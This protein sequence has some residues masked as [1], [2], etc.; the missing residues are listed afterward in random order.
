MTFFYDEIQRGLNELEDGEF[1]SKSI[2][3]KSDKKRRWSVINFDLV[4]EKSIFS[5]ERFVP[6]QVGS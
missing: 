4:D 2:C 1:S 3:K 5:R 6:K